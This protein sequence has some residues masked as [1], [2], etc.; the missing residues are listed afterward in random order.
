MWRAVLVFS[1]AILIHRQSAFK[2]ILARN[3]YIVFKIL[4]FILVV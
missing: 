4:I 1:A 3:F 2:N